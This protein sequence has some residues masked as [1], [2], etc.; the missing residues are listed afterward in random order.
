M[1]PTYKQIVLHCTA[2][3]EDNKIL[4]RV[5]RQGENYPLKNG[6]HVKIG[7]IKMELKEIV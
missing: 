2:N 7:K 1:Q 3:T 6:T 5:I 4:W